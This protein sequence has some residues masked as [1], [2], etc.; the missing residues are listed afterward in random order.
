MSDQQPNRNK[1]KHTSE[2][3]PLELLALIAG[4]VLSNNAATAAT[5]AT[6]AKKRR[7]ED[8]PRLSIIHK[9]LHDIIQAYVN[10]LTVLLRSSTCSTKLSTSLRG[11]CSYGTFDAN[12]NEL[13]LRIMRAF[14]VPTIF[15]E[16]TTPRQNAQSIVSM[17]IEIVALHNRFCEV[18]TNGYISVSRTHINC[19][20]PTVISKIIDRLNEICKHFREITE[21]YRPFIIQRLS[22]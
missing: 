22:D 7:L 12:L 5:A 2:L 18:L 15:S 20:K 11:Y 21:L 16:S 1:R 14:N 4:I 6:A 3:T 8:E 19:V 9:Q 10:V 17:I 13:C